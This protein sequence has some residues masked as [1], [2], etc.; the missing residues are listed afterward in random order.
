VL[1]SFVLMRPAWTVRMVFGTVLLAAGAGAI[2]FWKVA[3]EET[4]LSL[5]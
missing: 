4:V 2:L 3:E 5:R 1:E